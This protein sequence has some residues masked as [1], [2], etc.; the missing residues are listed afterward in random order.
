MRR[1]RACIHR[2]TA[3]AQPMPGQQDY[4]AD[5]YTPLDWYK[6]QRDR[7]S[8]Q[9]ATESLTDDQLTEASSTD[10]RRVNERLSRR[11]S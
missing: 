11:E 5:R 1:V 3:A 4:F 6:R 9:S 7:V 8:T 2:F 10:C